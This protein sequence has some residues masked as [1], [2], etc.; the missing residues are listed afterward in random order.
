MQKAYF[1]SGILWGSEVK[2]YLQNQ[3]F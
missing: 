1:Q 3:S 2:M